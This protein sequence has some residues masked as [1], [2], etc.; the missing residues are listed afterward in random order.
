MVGDV[1]GMHGKLAQQRFKCQKSALFQRTDLPRKFHALNWLPS[2]LSDKDISA[3]T[4]P[5]ASDTPL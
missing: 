4:P 1:L 2:Y 3:V 5:F